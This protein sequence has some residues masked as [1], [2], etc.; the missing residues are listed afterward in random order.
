MKRISLSVVLAACALAFV[1]A[2]CAAAP[3]RSVDS[4]SLKGFWVLDKST[5]VGFDAALNLDDEELAEFMIADSY[6]EGSWKTDGKEATVMFAGDE[7]QTA[8]MYVSEDK[9]TL[10]D[11]N[12]SKLVFVKGNMDEYFAADE[13]RDNF[14]VAS[15]SA[16]SED[17]DIVEEVINDIEPIT[18]ADDEICK[19][20]VTGKGTDFT[21]DPGYRLS[22]TNYTDSSVY[23]LADD[24][25][26]VG[27]TEIA[28][29]M[30]EVVQPGKT[31][32]TFMYFP[33][34]EV[35][36]GAEKLTSVTGK[37]VVGDDQ[38]GNEIATYDVE[39]S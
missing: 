6:L 24:M 18:I 25:F 26:K 15:S 12:G 17:P 8:K 11:G 3:A 9:L 16:E 2:G 39:L 36:G 20:E 37:I 31:L 28:P 21:G 5:P 33:K 35:G 30:G 22:L 1:L 4:D 29:G 19:I 13:H 32:E 38:T 34:D 23:I 10:G 7:E 27:K 14:A